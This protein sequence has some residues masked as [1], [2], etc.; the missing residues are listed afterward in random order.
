M[1]EKN[2]GGK[3]EWSRVCMVE[4]NDGRK[5]TVRERLRGGRG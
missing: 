2:D 4:K 3:N 5:E 1:K